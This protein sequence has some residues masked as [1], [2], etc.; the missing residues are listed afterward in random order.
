MVVATP[1]LVATPVLL[2]TVG[3]FGPI[4]VAPP[5]V[6]LLS[7]VYPVAVLLNASRAVIV[8]LFAAPAVG[9]VVAAA[10]R[11]FAAVAGLTVKLP[12]VPA[13]VGEP[14]LSVAVSVVVSAFLRVIELVES[15]AAPLVNVTDTG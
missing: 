13:M 4:A 9:V 6:R 7:P 11:R 3:L 10:S 8:R 2:L 5:K 15:V 12:D 1:K 14:V